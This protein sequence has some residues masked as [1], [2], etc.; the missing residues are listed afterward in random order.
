MRYDIY[1]LIYSIYLSIKNKSFYFP[2][3]IQHFV[4][5]SLHIYLCAYKRIY[6]MLKIQKMTVQSS[7]ALSL[8][9]NLNVCILAFKLL[10]MH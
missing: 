5:K 7:S 3:A 1:S 6:P 2:Q 9:L 8:Q 10:R 4:P